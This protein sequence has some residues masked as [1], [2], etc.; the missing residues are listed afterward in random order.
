MANNTTCSLV[1]TC[2]A[3]GLFIV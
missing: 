2:Q 1:I 3:P